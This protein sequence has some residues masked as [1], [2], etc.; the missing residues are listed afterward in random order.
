MRCS[1]RNVN[2]VPR[3]IGPLTS[4]Q[5]TLDLFREDDLIFDVQRAVRC[6]MAHRHALVCECLDIAWLSYAC[7]SEADDVPIKVLYF[8]LKA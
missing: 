8:A 3:P 2:T 6:G 5:V 4:T 1:V 7:A